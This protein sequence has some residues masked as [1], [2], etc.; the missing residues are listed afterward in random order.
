MEFGNCTMF[1]SAFG[2]S[3]I[4]FRSAEIVRRFR[5]GADM[6]RFRGAQVQKRD[7]VE[8]HSGAPMFPIFRSEEVQMRV[9]SEVQ[10][11]SSAVHTSEIQKLDGRIS[12]P[13]RSNCYKT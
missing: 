4:R 7:A 8:V 13:M 5:T 9:V 10:R 1:S 3:E 11:F 6:Q 2:I 12:V